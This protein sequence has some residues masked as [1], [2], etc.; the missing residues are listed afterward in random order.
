M[1]I[2]FVCLLAL[3]SAVST[4]DA[5]SGAGDDYGRSRPDGLIIPWRSL[6]QGKGLE[7]WLATASSG[8]WSRGDNAIVGRLD[9]KRKSHIFQG[10]SGWK[11]YE[12][13]LFV[14]LEKGSCMQFPFRVTDDGKGFYFVEFDYAWQTINVTLRE[15]DIHGVTKLSVVNYALEK[16]REYHLI[17]SARHQSLTTYI[18]GKLVNQVTDARYGG[19]GVGIAMW[20]DTRATYR[21]PKIRHYKW[22]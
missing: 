8:G 5:G 19:G 7:G 11:N 2:L 20:W 9:G 6:L 21:D 18:D 22:P 10:D 17:I 14:T 1:N 15:P 16:G 12:Y 3:L 13:S 4:V